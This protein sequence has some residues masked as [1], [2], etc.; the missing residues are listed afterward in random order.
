MRA[1]PLLTITRQQKS[2]GLVE[3]FFCND[4]ISKSCQALGAS[5]SVASPNPPRR[6]EVAEEVQFQPP[7]VAFGYG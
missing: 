6:Q 4:D 3:R 5:E 2:L 7:S 1:A